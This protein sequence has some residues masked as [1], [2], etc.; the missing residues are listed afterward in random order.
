MAGSNTAGNE[1]I[2]GMPG[3]ILHACA[4]DCY[5]YMA[6]WS[7]ETAGSA[8]GDCPIFHASALLTIQPQCMTICQERC[9]D[10]HSI[11]AQ[12]LLETAKTD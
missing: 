12:A 1:I 11:V 4:R 8:R 10:I 9:I 6:N 5:E 3:S 7:D 2:E